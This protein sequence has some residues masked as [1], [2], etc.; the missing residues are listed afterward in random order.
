MTKCVKHCIGKF[1]RGCGLEVG[2]LETVVF[3][4]KVPSQLYVGQ[5]M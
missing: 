2:L 1:V 3:G 5:T 4:E